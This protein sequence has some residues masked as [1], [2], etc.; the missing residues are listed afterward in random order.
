M[1]VTE[2]PMKITSCAG[3]FHWW[4]ISCVA[5][6]TAGCVTA[7]DSGLDA[8]A[9]AVNNR[10]VAYMGQFD[11][12]SATEVFSELA[13]RYPENAE[14]QVNLGIA[15]MNR[16]GEGDE[17]TA[18]AIFDGVLAAEPSRLVLYAHA[19]LGNM[20]EAWGIEPQSQIG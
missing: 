17:E 12:P 14:V 6:I 5:A 1:R 16:Q 2:M 9:V 13:Q 3:V 7:S 15:I 4:A 18:K 20:V 11:F 19:N 10:G 8:E